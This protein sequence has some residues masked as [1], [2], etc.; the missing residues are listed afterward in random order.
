M[1]R[2]PGSN[3]CWLNDVG[4]LVLFILYILYRFPCLPSAEDKSAYHDPNPHDQLGPVDNRSKDIERLMEHWISVVCS[5]IHITVCERRP[6]EGE[7]REQV[8]TSVDGDKE[9]RDSSNCSSTVDIDV[10]PSDT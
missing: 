5:S 4:E 8:P 10:M 7:E 1:D 9:E 2:S 3:P 6:T